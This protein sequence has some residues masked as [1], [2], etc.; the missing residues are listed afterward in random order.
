MK[1]CSGLTVLFTVIGAVV[2]IAG[3][4]ILASKLIQK[5]C[6]ELL[7]DCC[8]DDDDDWDFDGD[9]DDEEVC[10]CCEEEKAEEE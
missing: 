7:Y 8:P 2:F 3:L 9:E 1:K 4:A 10:C 5:F 6:P